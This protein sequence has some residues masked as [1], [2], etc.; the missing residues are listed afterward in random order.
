MNLNRVGAIISK[1]FYWA[2]SN[3]KLLGITLMPALMNIFFAKVA[4]ASTFAVG[5]SFSISF[6]GVFLTSFLLIEEKRRGTLKALLTTPLTNSELLFGKFIFTFSL[7]LLIA[8]FGLAINKR[9]DLFLNPFVML[10]I[11]IF[12]ATTCFVGFIQGLFFKNE[13]EMSIAAPIVMVLFVIGSA[14]DDATDADV[15][16]FFPDYHFTHALNS[17]ELSNFELLYHTTYSFIIAAVTFIFAVAFARFYFSNNEE[18]R[19]STKL[20][21][22]LASFLGVFIISGLISPSLIQEKKKTKEAGFA[23]VKF[24]SNAWRG[25]ISYDS[26]AVILKKVLNSKDMKKFKFIKDDLEVSVQVRV[27]RF[28]EEFEKNREKKIR[29]KKFTTI[30]AKE[31]LIIKSLKFRKWVYLQDKNKLSVL[32]ESFC[33]KQ[34]FQVF[35]DVEKSNLEK[36]SKSVKLLDQILLKTELECLDGK[37][38]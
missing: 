25:E 33:N 23:T 38:I 11:A 24:K 22:Y 14:I 2:K 1:D 32:V 28:H 10:N 7:C 12:S 8:C 21:L 13:Q 30:L 6:L 29:S 15:A 19:F 9:F 3:S 37:P 4:G 16:A 20:T 26:P 34:L 27:T 31:D 17:S 36:V 18:K 35:F 5:L